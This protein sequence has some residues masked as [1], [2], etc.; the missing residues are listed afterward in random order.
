MPTPVG[1]E[2]EIDI[3]MLS[4]LEIDERVSPH[5]VR[6]TEHLLQ[7]GPRLFTESLADHKQQLVKIVIEVCIVDFLER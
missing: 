3:I 6:L 7:R 4:L 1:C 2:L 5:S